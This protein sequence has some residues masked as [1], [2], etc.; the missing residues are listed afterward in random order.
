[1]AAESEA[2]PKRVITLDSVGA[3]ALKSKAYFCM[4]ALIRED[5]KAASSYDQ[6]LGTD[7]SA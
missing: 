7:F 5:F 4:D 3:A 2:V 1:M 6:S